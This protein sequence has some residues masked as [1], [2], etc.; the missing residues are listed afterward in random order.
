MLG[1]QKTIIK[2][3]AS[4][5]KPVVIALNSTFTSNTRSFSGINLVD[6]VA[7]RPGRWSIDI[8]A[9]PS[10][11]LHTLVD[12]CGN[13][14]LQLFPSISNVSGSDNIECQAAVWL[15]QELS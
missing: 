11:P 15:L 6:G 1:L 12:F 7:C 3:S 10:K 13:Y 4:D 5:G 2:C 14:T 8:P 9:G